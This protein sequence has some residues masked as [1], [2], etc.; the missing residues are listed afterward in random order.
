MILVLGHSGYGKNSRA[1]NTYLI[2]VNND[3]F[4]GNAQ[5]LFRRKINPSSFLG[6]SGNRVSEPSFPF[7][8][9]L[10][11]KEGAGGGRSITLPL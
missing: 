10:L 4:R 11:C 5:E 3:F 7:L 1:A 2:A 6:L 8:N 9:P